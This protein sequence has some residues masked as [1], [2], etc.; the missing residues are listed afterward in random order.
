[1]NIPDYADHVLEVVRTIVLQVPYEN[2]WRMVRLEVLKHLKGTHTYP[3]IVSMFIQEGEHY[4]S[5]E[6]PE[7]YPRLGGDSADAAMNGFLDEV[8]PKFAE[9]AR[10]IEQRN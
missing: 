5:W 7:G 4:G 6:E 8:L 9:I 10:G 3:F 1:M 2:R